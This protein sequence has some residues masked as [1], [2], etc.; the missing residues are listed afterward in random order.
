[1][2]K[3]KQNYIVASHKYFELFE[4][5]DLKG[6][7]DIYD[8]KIHLIDWNGEWKGKQAVLDMNESL[9]NSKPKI[10]VLEII[11]SDKEVEGLQRTYCKIQID[12]A[13]ATLKVLDIIDWSDDHKIVKIEAFNG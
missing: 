6:L 9:F 7:K 12:I 4:N 3:Y 13:G 11:Q 5:Y 8:T 1:M 10:T 2:N